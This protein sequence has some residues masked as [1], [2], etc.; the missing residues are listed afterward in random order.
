V[1]DE[2][3]SVAWGSSKLRRAGGER[4]ASSSPSHRIRDASIRLFFSFFLFSFS[5]GG[6]LGRFKYLL[7]FWFLRGGRVKI[8]R[9]LFGFLLSMYS[10]SSF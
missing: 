5:F 1:I 4:I 8:R 7:V 6:Y 3:V 9:F 10:S 2:G